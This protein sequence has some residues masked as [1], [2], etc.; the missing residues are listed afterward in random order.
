MIRRAFLIASLLAATPPLLAA[1]PARAASDLTVIY[2]GGLDCPPCTQW[3]S[4]QKA[5][6]LA[7]PEYKQVTWVEVESPKL[8]DAYKER[9]WPDG[10]R[11][12]LAQLPRKS[13]TPRFL[14]VRD[15]RVVSNE[16]GT[17]RWAATV[18]ELKKELGE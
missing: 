6:W 10:L 1:G 14:I 16:F 12:V 7:S 18:A 5:R 3:K 4:T 11:P 13:G 17:G 15:G 9:Y 8:R 2:V